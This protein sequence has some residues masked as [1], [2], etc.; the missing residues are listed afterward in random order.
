MRIINKIYIVLI[1]ISV[2]I[3]AQNNVQSLA[4]EQIEGNFFENNS[5]KVVI[6]KDNFEIS[7]DNNVVFDKNITGIKKVKFSEDENFTIIQNYKFAEKSE[8]SLLNSFVYNSKYNLVASFQDTIYRD[9][10]AK[11]YSVNNNGVVVIFDPASSLLSVWENNEIRTLNFS[12]GYEFDTETQNIIS[13]D[14]ENVYIVRNVTNPAAVENVLEN[15][16][17]YKIEI[18]TKQFVKRTYPISVVT[19]FNLINEELIISGIKHNNGTAVNTTLFIN[20]NLEITKETDLYKFDKAVNFGDVVVGL[21]GNNVVTYNK[22]NEIKNEQKYSGDGRFINFYENEK[23]LF[24]IIEEGDNLNFYPFVLENSLFNL[25]NKT[26][27]LSALPT[28]TII[29][30]KNLYLLGEELTYKIK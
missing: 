13:I 20:D 21:A 22:D 26:V 19:C 17:L 18:K 9:Y 5:Y 11:M 3:S 16:T 6:E 24:L 7:I 8:L 28:Y 10:P 15:T 23:S 2:Q 30:L 27:S 14:E 25:G 29:N 12:D 4:V 1:F